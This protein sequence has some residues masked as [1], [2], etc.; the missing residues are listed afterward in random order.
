MSKQMG[1]YFRMGTKSRSRAAQEL[2]IIAHSLMLDKILM[3]K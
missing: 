2:S 1:D 3:H